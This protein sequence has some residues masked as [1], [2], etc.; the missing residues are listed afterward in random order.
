MFFNFIFNPF[1]LIFCQFIIQA[2]FLTASGREDILSDRQWN[3][4]LR[5]AIAPAFLQ[6]VERFHQRPNLE[7][8]WF[9]YIPRHKPPGF[10]R[11]IRSSILEILKR[12]RLF[13]CRDGARRA[14][15]SV[16]VPLAEYK[17][18]DGNPLV[19]EKYIRKKYYL[20][21]QYSTDRHGATLEELGVE[22][23]SPSAFVDALR[24]MDKD[25]SLQKQSAEWYNHVCFTLQPILARRRKLRKPISELRIIP[26]TQQRS[27]VN[28]S[29]GN[30]FFDSHLGDVPQDMDI[31]LV[32]SQVSNKSY[33]YRLLRDLDVKEADVSNI[34]HQ[35]LSLHSNPSLD[36]RHHSALPSHARFLFRHESELSLSAGFPFWVLTR[37]GDIIRAN[38][39][40][41]NH[42]SYQSPS[43]EEY[44]QSTHGRFLH[45]DYFDV[46]M[47]T[48]T[49][50]RWNSFLRS[51]LGLNISPR[52]VNNALS[53]EFENFLANSDTTTILS[54]LKTFW[55]DL[56]PKLE[57]SS[58][59]LKQ[60]Q[61]VRVRTSDGALRAF[62]KSFIAR[63]TLRRFTDL[64]F[65]VVQ[66]PE[67]KS[68][69]FLR[70]LGV[71]FEV[72]SIF[73]LNRLVHLSETYPAEAIPEEQVYECYQQL[74]ARFEDDAK[75]NRIRLVVDCFR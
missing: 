61:G 5:N 11:P 57:D 27:W 37:N 60:L 72:D 29:A 54:F 15:T 56:A 51:R 3:I 25:G 12:S 20:S 22:L 13:L 18:H 10:M 63:N 34:A 58:D 59:S 74:E 7:F 55:S 30:V 40:Y 67:N 68:W 53:P 17:D 69:D 44:F 65:I 42:S 14:G 33:H 73:Y 39:A 16:I 4:V 75:S 1:E 45:N 9:Q 70:K 64:P 6:A 71:S 8:D 36:T 41:M 52:V 62:D 48:R 31:N 28:A 19:P 46:S 24:E 23:M 2:D 32:A 47:D 26:L 43:L 49:S 38:D 21:A 50:S 66:D 35:L